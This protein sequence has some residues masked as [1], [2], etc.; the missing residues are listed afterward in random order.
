M[1]SISLLVLAGVT[2]KTDSHLFSWKLRSF[3]LERLHF[4]KTTLCSQPLYFK[5]LLL[6]C[7]TCLK[8]E[9]S[10]NRYFR[11]GRVKMS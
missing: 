9:L 10:P 2:G 4:S 6:S 8:K 11:N 7:I 5:R 1:H 3:S